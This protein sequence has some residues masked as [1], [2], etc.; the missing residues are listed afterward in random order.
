MSTELSAAP[1]VSLALP[2]SWLRLDD[3]ETLR[4]LADLGSGGADAGSTAVADALRLLPQARAAGVAA[5][6]SRL[7]PGRET[8]V[9]LTWPGT[10]ATDVDAIL[11]QLGPED[12]AAAQPLEHDE[13]WPLVRIPQADVPAG[14]GVLYWC[15]DPRSG[16]LLSLAVRRA[17]GV[18][19]DSES[20]L[21]DALAATLS[22]EEPDA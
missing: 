13:G 22:W 18:L 3:P 4:T 21:Y 17:E 8:V 1:E 19:T 14:A 15:A 16:R 20:R 7:D 9:A 5:I 2:G 10:L 11:A 6:L 12:A